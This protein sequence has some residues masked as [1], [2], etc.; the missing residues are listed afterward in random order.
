[1]KTKFYL[2]LAFL[3]TSVCVSLQAQDQPRK[4]PVFPGEKMIKELKLTD[5]QVADLKKGDAD[6]RTQMQSLRDQNLPREER[7]A[8]MEKLRTSR[9]EMIKKILTEEQYKA[10]IE[11]R[12]KQ[13]NR[14]QMQGRPDGPRNDGGFGPGNGGGIRPDG[15]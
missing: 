2:M 15:E 11:M 4:A 13:E 10:Y 8:A 1:M 6:I 7:R 12:Q 9:D 3:L 14:R 5:Q